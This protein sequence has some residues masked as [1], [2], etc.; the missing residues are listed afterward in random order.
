[1]KNRAAD[2]ESGLRPTQEPSGHRETLALRR[3]YFVLVTLGAK[4][5]EGTRD[6]HDL[7]YLAGAEKDAQ[8][9]AVGGR[10]AKVQVEHAGEHAYVVV[11]KSV[12]MTL[13]ERSGRIH[14]VVPFEIEQS[15]HGSS[16]DCDPQSCQR[17]PQ[18]G[19]CRRRCPFVE[20]QRAIAADVTALDAV[21]SAADT[22]R[23][24][25]AGGIAASRLARE[26]LHDGRREEVRHDCDAILGDGIADACERIA[27]DRR[28]RHFQVRLQRHELRQC[29]G[30]GMYSEASSYNAADAEVY[31]GSATHF[32]RI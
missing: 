11:A 14:R 7:A 4:T 18:C 10:P 6:R 25:L 21:L 15:E 12:A 20:P 8:R 1:M 28:R 19:L 17:G 22:R 13:I 24:E 29:S 5:H 2:E 30:D 16:I 3:Q 32:S 9:S 26:C 31:P 27:V 23:A